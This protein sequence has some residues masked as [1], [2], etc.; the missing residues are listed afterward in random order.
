MSSRGF[1]LVETLVG[2]AVFWVIAL[3]VYQVYT[4][5]FE[6]ANF[7]ETKIIA[8]ALA[9]EQVEIIR[10]IP[11]SDIGLVSGIPVGV[12]E[13]VQNITNNTKC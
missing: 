11:F 1:G 2:V 5:L 10:N 6:G 4:R 12:I 9:N 3:T 13:P 7:S 8:A